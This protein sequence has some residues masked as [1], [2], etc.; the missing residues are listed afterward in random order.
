MPPT[1]FVISPFTSAMAARKS[2]G[3]TTWTLVAARSRR[4][5]LSRWSHPT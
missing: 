3:V 4:R 5:A 2:V 1:S